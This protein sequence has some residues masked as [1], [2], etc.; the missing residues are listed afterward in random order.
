MV[1]AHKSS[2]STPS[3]SGRPKKSTS[4]TLIVRLKLSSSHLAKFLPATTAEPIKT[5][6]QQ[7]QQQ[8]SSSKPASSSSS[9]SDSKAPTAS[10]LAEGEE[11]S[12]GNTPV[13]SGTDDSVAMPP[14]AEAGGKAAGKGK[15]RASLLVDGVVKPRGKPGPKKRKL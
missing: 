6:P 4:K 13:P 7:Q 1:S 14:P 2:P 3:G 8:D 11:A 10:P 12:S 15:K 9:L 5:E